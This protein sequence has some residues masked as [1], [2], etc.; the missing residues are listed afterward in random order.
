MDDELETLSH[1]HTWTLIP[2][3]FSMNIVRSRQVFKVKLKANGKVERLKAWLIAKGQHQLD[4]IDFTE[5]HSQVVKPGT[6]RLVLSLATVKD[7]D[8]R[9]LYVKNAF[10]HGFLNEE[11]FMEHPLGFK[12]SNFFQ[13]CLSFKQSTLWIKINPKG[14]V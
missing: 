1:N 9:Q 4:G 2:R 10:L 6:I 5:T 13:S 8:I 11:V 7:W 14:L 12:D 3:T